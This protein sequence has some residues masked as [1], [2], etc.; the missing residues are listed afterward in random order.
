MNRSL[1]EPSA[2]APDWAREGYRLAA[3]EGLSVLAA[4]GMIRRH[5]ASLRYWIVVGEKKRMTAKA[6]RWRRENPKRR[7]ELGRRGAA[8]RRREKGDEVRA[9]RRAYS[10]RAD[11][12]GTCQ[13]CGE[14]MGVDNSLDGTCSACVLEIAEARRERIVALWGEG[15]SLKEI[16]AALETTA[17]SIGTEMASMRRRGYDLPKRRGR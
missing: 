10:R 7:R 14:M 12:R 16:A 13:R 3:E 9:A 11:R 17:N 2:D 6:R 15:L 1:C 4:A 5:A 8:K